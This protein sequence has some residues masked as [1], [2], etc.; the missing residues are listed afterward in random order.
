M[1]VG[2]VVLGLE[3]EEARWLLPLVSGLNGLVVEV[4]AGVVGF[5]AHSLCLLSTILQYCVFWL[6]QT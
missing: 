6:Q 5:A 2:V 1:V 4:G 3:K